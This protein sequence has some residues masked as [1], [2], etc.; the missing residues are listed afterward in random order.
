MKLYPQGE[1]LVVRRILQEQIGSII[2]PDEAQKESLEGEVVEAGPDCRL[3]KAGDT[4]IFGRYSGFELPLNGIYKDCL[5][6][7]EI[8]VLAKT[9]GGT[10]NDR[11]STQ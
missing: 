9:E 7:N 4:I 1:R 10:D 5:I 2:I 3:V 11:P 8:D 6:M